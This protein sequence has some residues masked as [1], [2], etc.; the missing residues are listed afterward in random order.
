MQE[1]RQSALT[2]VQLAT[3]HLGELVGVG[4]AAEVYRGMDLTLHREVAVKVLLGELSLDRDYVR[5]FREEARRVAALEHAHVVPVYYFG[6]ERGHLF[7]VMPLLRGGSLRQRLRRKKHLAPEEAVRIALDVASALEAAHRA[8]LIHRDVKPENILFNAQG[9]ALLTDFGLARDL[10]QDSG[11]WEQHNTTGI[12]GIPVGTPEYMAPEQFR[13]SASLDQRVDIY[14][15]GVVLYEMLTG[16]V[17]F[18]GSPRDLAARATSRLCPPPSTRAPSVWPAL[19]P[20]V[21]TALAV[22]PEGRYP[23]AAEFATALRQT[24]TTHGPQIADVSVLETRPVNVV[25]GAPAGTAELPAFYRLPTPPELMEPEPWPVQYSTNS[26]RPTVPRLALVLALVLLLAS[27]STG[28]VVLLANALG[29]AASPPLASA[30]PTTP[31]TPTPTASPKR[32]PRATATPTAAYIPPPPITPTPT[33]VVGTGLLGRYYN[34]I[35]NTQTPP[36]PCGA[37][38]YQRVDADI[39]FA[40]TPPNTLPPDNLA[41]PPSGQSY[42]G[43]C[44]TGYVLPSFSQTYTFQAYVTGEATVVINGTTLINLP[45]FSFS[46]SGSGTIL[47]TAGQRATITISYVGEYASY[48]KQYNAMRL[49]WQS[50]SQSGEIVP[51]RA[52]FPS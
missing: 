30:S 41:P 19:D 23:S 33:P 38:A 44:W 28:G 49:F 9:D 1:N 26:G 32:T 8:H 46:Q 29:S 20:R 51:Q 31:A 22:A 16:Q 15:L 27:L 21:M 18:V 17:P 40:G 13:R 36:L 6:E 43:A 37:P 47:L 45:Q 50:A 42:F 14:A 5:R 2:G 24:A 7:L 39:N 12:Y 52:L 34:N 4:G 25:S 3:F 48:Y 10:P 11:V 35:P